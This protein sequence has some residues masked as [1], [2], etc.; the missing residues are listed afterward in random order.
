MSVKIELS[1]V[2]LAYP[3]LNYHRG[4]LSRV[5]DA[6]VGQNLARLPAE[7]VALNGVSLTIFEGERVG[8]VGKN[9]AGKST[10]L[11]V[12]SGVYPPTQGTVQ[13]S[14]SVQGIYDIGTGFEMH[15]S[16]RQNILYRGLIMGHTPDQIRAREEE[17]IKFTGLGDRINTPLASYSTGMIVRLA[18]AISTILT[19]DILVVDEIF[20]A[21][22]INFQ[23]KAA[24]RMEKI[25]EDA[26]ILVF[27]SHNLA[28]V[29]ELCT[30]GIWIDGGQI[31]YD[32]AI[33]DTIDAY[34]EHTQ[35]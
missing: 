21:G 7:V 17:I 13:A 29:S 9:G 22:D 26:K 4:L 2:S 1:S 19:G 32:G 25:M 16:G 33:D 20:S 24:R 14:G 8:I 15:Q 10:L 11:R 30:R 31:A 3:L 6:F 28:Q 18:F 34:V 27:C 12:L 5:A 23:N 35:S